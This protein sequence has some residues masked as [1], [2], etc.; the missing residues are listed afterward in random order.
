MSAPVRNIVPPNPRIEFKAT[1]DLTLYAG[2]QVISS[3]FR[4]NKN[5]GTGPDG[6]NYGNAL[7]DFTEI[8][9]GAGASWK[10]CPK[11]TLD[12]ELGY[13]AYRDF[14]YHKVGENFQSRSGAFYGQMG[15][16]M[17]F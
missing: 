6:R 4:V 7:V 13:M 2:G 12:V 11:S 17:S 3:T 14:D 15:L 10:M 9:T 16:K 5:M 1:D 8:R